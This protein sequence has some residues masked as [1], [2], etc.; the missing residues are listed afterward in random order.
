MMDF[1]FY[2]DYHVKVFNNAELFARL[3]VSLMN[4]SAHYTYKESVYNDSNELIGYFTSPLYSHYTATNYALGYK[5]GKIELMLG[6]YT[7]NST[8]YFTKSERFT[9][10]YIKLNFNLFK[11]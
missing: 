9:V 10:P 8:A 6:V 4:R 1:H 11:F 5:K 3:G 7:T 2:L